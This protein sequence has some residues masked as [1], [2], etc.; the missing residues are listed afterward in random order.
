MQGQG[1]GLGWNVPIPWAWWIV[2]APHLLACLTIKHK[3]VPTEPHMK[4]RWTIDSNK[5]NERIKRIDDAD[6]SR[7]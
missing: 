3:I 6:I 2:R 5:R 4:P 1:D 7:S